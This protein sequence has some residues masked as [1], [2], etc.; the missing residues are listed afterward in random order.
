MAATKSRPHLNR[1]HQAKKQELATGIGPLQITAGHPQSPG[2]RR[3]ACTMPARSA[4]SRLLKYCPAKSFGST[5][6][7]CFS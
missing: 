2:K 7:S 5:Q 1:P 6:M 3:A 4:L